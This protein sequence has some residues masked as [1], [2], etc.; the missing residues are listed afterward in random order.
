MAAARRGDVEPFVRLDQVEPD[1]AYFGEKD[2]QQL[3][4]VRRM[5]A[6]MD[7]ALEIVG[8]PTVRE[9]DGLALSSRNLRLSRAERAKALGLPEALRKGAETHAVGGDAVA[10]TRAALNGL[11]PEYVELIDLDGVT[12][13]AS[14]VRL[15]STRLID[16]V[17]LEGE[18]P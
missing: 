18:L 5:V 16:N 1:A 6:D 14:A 7:F 9:P 4:V 17:I 15:G 12:I 13:L 3:A 11:T 2:F 8:V 10:A